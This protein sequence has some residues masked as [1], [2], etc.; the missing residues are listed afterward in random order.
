MEGSERRGKDVPGKSKRVKN[1]RGPIGGARRRGWRRA[2]RKGRGAR[3]LVLRVPAAPGARWAAHLAGAWSRFGRASR[4]SPAPRAARPPS[5]PRGRPR[6]V[7]R[8][9]RLWALLP[10]APLRRGDGARS[11]L[12]SLAPTSGDP[13]SGDCEARGGWGALGVSL[14]VLVPRLQDHLGIVA[15]ACRARPDGGRETPGRRGGPGA[16]H[17]PAGGRA[18]GGA[19]P[20]PREGRRESCKAG[21]R[22]PAGGAAGRRRRTPERL[23]PL[24]PLRL[25]RRPR[26]AGGGG[27]DTVRPQPAPTA[28]PRW[29]RASWPGQRA[30]ATSGGGGAGRGPTWGRP[31]TRA[32]LRPAWGSARRG[33]EPPSRSSC[34]PIGNGREERK[35]LWGSG[36]LV[37][38]LDPI[39]AESGAQGSPRGPSSS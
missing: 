4:S 1:W 33:H 20:S 36:P 11:G 15:P 9:T 10:A 21:R 16:A 27:G 37:E 26:N 17:S 24:P 35:A 14:P 23:Q 6:R 34:P 32:L 13:L 12:G 7:A 22:L 38:V 25:S 31:A 29:T 30:R 5:A 2:E 18:E 19:G 28:P 8:R 39:K 3:A